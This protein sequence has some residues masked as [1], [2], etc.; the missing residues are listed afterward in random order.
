MSRNVLKCG[1]AVSVGSVV[2]DFSC[3]T[4]AFWMAIFR[5]GASVIRYIPNLAAAAGSF[6]PFGMKNA[7]PLTKPAPYRSAMS[8]G[9][10][11]VSY[12][13]FGAKFGA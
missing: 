9:N 13:R 11:A 7:L 6:E 3:G 12:L 2:S 10:G 4:L 5:E 8:D 1:T